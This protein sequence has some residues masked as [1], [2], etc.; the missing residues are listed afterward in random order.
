M[1]IQK[2]IQV[3]SVRMPVEGASKTSAHDRGRYP[4]RRAGARHSHLRVRSFG[5]RKAANFTG[6]SN[7]APSLAIGGIPAWSR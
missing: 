3:L 4:G 1:L 5:M 7:T 6:D 2:H